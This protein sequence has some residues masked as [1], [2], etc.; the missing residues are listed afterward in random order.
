MHVEYPPRYKLQPQR[1]CLQD[2]DI[3]R[4]R[5]MRAR[6]FSPDVTAYIVVSTQNDRDMTHGNDIFSPDV[7]AYSD[8]DPKLTVT[9]DLTHSAVEFEG[10]HLAHSAVGFEGEMPRV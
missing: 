4:K 7:T 9:H 8:V 2:W 6:I 5:E 3:Q 1:L 10:C